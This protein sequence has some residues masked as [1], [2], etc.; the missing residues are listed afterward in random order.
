MIVWHDGSW[1]E[2]TKA[3][4]SLADRGGLLGDGLFETMRVRGGQLVRG[5]A[6]A[7]RLIRSC[8][9][10]GLCCPIDEPELEDLV[11][12]LVQ[13]NDLHDA[14]IRLTVSAGAGARGLPRAE[15][16]KTVMT[17]V[18]HSPADP[19][20]SVSLQTSTIRRSPSSPATAHKTLSYIDNVSA[21]RQAKTAGADMALMLDT[22]GNLSGGDCANLFWYI[23]DQLFTP[24]L[25][26]GVL[27]G[28]VRELV[29]ARMSAR[30]GCFHPG[31]LQ[32][33]NTVFLTN[34][35]I[36]IVPVDRIDG[37]KAACDPGRIEQVRRVVDI[38]ESAKQD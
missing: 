16:A 23:G 5:S 35:L 2:D 17:L 24:A 14:A 28:T 37:S 11:A 8:Q 9:A 19:P 21:R 15:D 4:R 38:S 36:G 13:R 22:A 1:L 18:G 34:A 29:L 3:S 32:Q 12:E 6:H 26:C 7:A 31:D 30:E 10:L 27:A 25:G 33:A 20:S